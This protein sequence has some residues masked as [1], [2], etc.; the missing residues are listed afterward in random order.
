MLDDASELGGCLYVIPGS[1]KIGTKEA[2]RDETT[3]S[4]PQWTIRKEIIRDVLRT[5]PSPVP[6]TGG[7]GTGVLF[8]CQ[9]VHASGHNLAANDRWH[10]YMAYNPSVNRPD[11]VPENPRPDYVVSQNYTPLVQAED[12]SLLEPVPA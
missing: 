4:Y 8:H 2:Y 10:V 7:P 11:P 1:H 12:D 3:T 9:I 5:S 6:I